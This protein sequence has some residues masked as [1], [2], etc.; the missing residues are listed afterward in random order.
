MTGTHEDLGTTALRARVQA[1]SPPMSLDAGQVLTA[2]RRSRRRRTA[3]RGLGA[4]CVL[5]V[6]GV[7]TAEVLTPHTAV[8]DVAGWWGEPTAEDVVALLGEPPDDPPESQV[9]L[10]EE[11]LG[12]HYLADLPD[13]VAYAGA[14]RE[15]NVCLILV[16]EELIGSS[17]GEP[18]RLA[19]SP[20]GQWASTSGGGV[21]LEATLVPDGA[22][23]PP[24]GWTAVHPNLWVPT[25]DTTGP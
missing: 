15:G 24:E 21:H 3:L 1:M 17:C 7:A 13:G 11:I 22:P 20:E 6:G 14:D 4:V 18:W 2:A 10:S 8:V 19:R 23:S 25:E 9:D 5:A 16:A 12:Y